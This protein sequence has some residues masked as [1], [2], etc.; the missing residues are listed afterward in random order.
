VIV[1]AA[2]SWSVANGN[3]INGYQGGTTLPNSSTIHFF[4]CTGAS[5]TASFASTSLTPT[6]PTGY[7]VSYRRIFSLWTDSAGKLMG[8]NGGIARET[9]GGSLA[10]FLGAQSTLD[11]NLTG[12]IA[13]A[14]RTLLTI[15]SIP[16]GIQVWVYYRAATGGANNT[17]MIFGSP[18]E[19]DVT[20]VSVAGYSFWQTS[21]GNDGNN[22]SGGYSII[23][24]RMALSN[25]SAQLAVRASIIDCSLYAQVTHFIDSRR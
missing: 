3:A 8:G 23:P 17:G 22:F 19:A 1:G 14:S 18:D 21:P 5:G 20:P 24:Q 4:V 12:S 6:L 25:T 2:Y 16:S 7:A 10:F 11:V 9:F 15:P 13:T